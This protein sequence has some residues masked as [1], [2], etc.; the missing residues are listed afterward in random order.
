[1]LDCIFVLG[2]GQERLNN[3]ILSETIFDQRKEQTSVDLS[4][5]ILNLGQL[6]EIRTGGS[7]LVLVTNFQHRISVP[8]KL[9]LYQHDSQQASQIAV[10]ILY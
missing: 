9:K 7:V 4:T 3:V 8:V 10:R 1:M 5:N 6:F 2:M